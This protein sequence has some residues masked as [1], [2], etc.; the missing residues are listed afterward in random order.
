MKGFFATAILLVVTALGAAEGTAQTNMATPGMGSASPLAT[1]IGGFAA[2]SQGVALPY[3]GAAN[4][5]PCSTGGYGTTAPAT[6][7]GGSSLSTNSPTSEPLGLY[8]VGTSTSTACSSVSTSG[9]TSSPTSVTTS[10]AGTNSS[11]G[12][13]PSSPSSS[14]STLDAASAVAVGLGTSG[15]GATGLGTV[16]LGLVPPA[17]GSTS[18][19]ASL[20]SGVAGSPTSCSGASGGSTSTIATAGIPSTTPITPLPTGAGAGGLVPDPAQGVASALYDPAQTLGGV[21]RLPSMNAA[22]APCN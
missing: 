3:S 2:D 22:G 21:A 19:A 18:Q 16:G 9:T 4:R 8:G 20:S 6:F 15:L 5:A 11:V 17:S 1:G 12:S 13:S 7:D 14:S 10:T